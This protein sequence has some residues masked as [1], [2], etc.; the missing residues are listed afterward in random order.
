MALRMRQE[1]AAQADREIA[2][3]A[4][5]DR[6]SDPDASAAETAAAR[7][8][9]TGVLGPYAE[10]V[11]GLCARTAALRRDHAALRGRLDE[12][13]NG[14][15]LRAVVTGV[16]DDWVR[17]FLG[18]TERV[19]ARPQG[20]D[21]GVGQTALT[22]ADGRGILAPGEYLVGGQSFEFCDVAWEGFVYVRSLRDGSTDDGRQLALL[23]DSVDAASL[24][25]GDRVLAWSV[26]A[27]NVLI[28]TLRL[29]PAQPVVRDD[30]AGTRTVLREDLVGLDEILEETELLFL[31]SRS[32]SYARLL[33]AAS[34]GLVGLV[35]HGSSGVGKSR[36][37]DYIAGLVRGRGGRALYRTASH[38]LSK[39]V[40]EGSATLRADFALL[41]RAFRESGVRPL[42]VIDE[43]EAIALD[44]G[45]SAALQAGH[46]DVLDTL[47]HLLTRSG[48]RMIGISN[49]ADRHLDAALL[50]DGRL[51]V[52]PFPRTLRADEV[53]AL[54]ERCLAG[55]P[56]DEGGAR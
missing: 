28:V 45:Q 52:V 5:L 55:V 29:G 17:V 7:S 27:G 36:A 9:V 31:D 21:L 3:E 53:A 50:R 51:R 42:L 41:E 20:I 10:S 43:L 46:L 47:L 6:S 49:V 19:L 34:P 33:D 16:A 40:G 11:L 38:Y 26:H 2:L 48:V 22:D 32:P 30:G 8:I 18:G 13:L 44:R 56:L 1:A 35:Y 15:R 54:V 37:A 14:A 25:P 39:W 4:V 12:I 24:R 23:A